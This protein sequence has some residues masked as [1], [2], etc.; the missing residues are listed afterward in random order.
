MVN[1]KNA[2]K[3]TTIQN[4]PVYKVYVKL[5]LLLAYAAV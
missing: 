1:G 5:L 2:V 3:K 4:G